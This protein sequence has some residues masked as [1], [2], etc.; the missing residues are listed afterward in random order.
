M[1]DGGVGDP[2]EAGGLAVAE[3]AAPGEA[4][5][6]LAHGDGLGEEHGRVGVVAGGEVLE[7]DRQNIGLS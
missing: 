1:L 4:F 6:R 2:A 7:G 5:G 3:D